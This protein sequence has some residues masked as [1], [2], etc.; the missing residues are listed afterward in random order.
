MYCIFSSFSRKARTALLLVFLLC[1]L[2]LLAQ[3]R[4]LPEHPRLLFTGA[5]TAKVKNLIQTDT[6]A[7]RLAEYLKHEADS[8]VTA[9]QLPNKLDKYGALL[10]TSRAYVY[11]LGTLSL[12]YRI[13]G[14]RKYLDA[15]NA[16]LVWVCSFPDW[17]P[18]HYLDTAEMTAAVAI[19]YDWLHADLPYDT[20]QLV[21]AS[22]YKNALYRVLREY[23][24]GGSGS[25]AKRNTNWNVVCNTGMVLGA[26]ALAEDYPQETETILD[27]AAKY[28]PNCLKLFAPD[29]VCY[30]GPAYWGY[31]NRYLAMYLKAVID[32]GGDRGNIAQLPGISRTALYQIR[33]LTPSGH[34]FYFGDAGIGHESFGGPAMFLYGKLFNQPEVSAWNRLE[35]AR[36]LREG[37]LFDQMFFLSLPWYDDAAATAKDVIPAMETYHNDINDIVIFNGRRSKKGSIYLEA[38]GG[39]PNQAHQQMDCGTF[40]V[41]TDGVLWTEDLGAEDYDVPGFWDG[42]VG[43]KRW[44]Y[45]RNNNFSHNVIHIDRSLQN[46]NGHAVLCEERPDAKQPYAKIDLSQVYSEKAKRAFR[47]FTLIDDCTME[48]EDDVTLLDAKSTVTWQVVTKAQVQVSGRNI[49][50]T[51]NGK[52]FYMQISAPAGVDIKTTPAKTSFSGEKPIEGYTIIEATCPFKGTDGKIKVRMSSKKR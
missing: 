29:G 14:D 46:A 16:S 1:S 30:E 51:R 44:T 50:L 3:Q 25:W 9:P 52:H 32:N 4:W 15:A 28:I 42:K 11:R 8:L 6:L 34:P 10:W 20:K 37:R 35:V 21:M 45:F 23:E 22:I 7:A 19:A 36:S 38:K 40:I 12:A 5:E 39:K 26:L 47:K 33:T 43:G 2:S 41:E 31:T 24:K 48:V 18:S 49:H 17:H 27:N 13:Y